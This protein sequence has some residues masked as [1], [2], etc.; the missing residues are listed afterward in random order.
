MTSDDLGK[1]ANQISEKEKANLFTAVMDYLE[2]ASQEGETSVPIVFH[3]FGNYFFVTEE[4]AV[5]VD[6]PAAIIKMMHLMLATSSPVRSIE[7]H[8]QY[9]YYVNKLS[10]QTL[11]QGISMQRNIPDSSYE[12]GLELA[13]QSSGIANQVI[14]ISFI[15]D[16]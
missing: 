1:L 12:A 6:S 3:P 16:M 2:A 14:A 5:C 9:G 15:D 10:S 13:I 4:G 8:L 7:D 11:N